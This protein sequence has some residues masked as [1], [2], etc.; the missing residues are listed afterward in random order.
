M[1]K[2][3][4]KK[5]LECKKHFFAKNLRAVYCSDRCRVRSNRKKSVTVT[6]KA[7]IVLSK[8]EILLKET[9]LLLEKEQMGIP[10]L[11]K[12][13]TE[14]EI[15]LRDREL[16]NEKIRGIKTKL[17]KARTYY[18]RI[19][20]TVKSG[21]EITKGMLADSAGKNLLL[22]ALAGFV[23]DKAMGNSIKRY[24]YSKELRDIDEQLALLG[25]EERII[26]FPFDTD[27]LKGE[28]QN[29]ARHI[30]NLKQ[31]CKEL[32]ET[33]LR[34]KSV[35]DLILLKDE[36]G[37]VS[38]KDVKNINFSDRIMLSGDMGIFIGA[39]EKNKCA[40]TLTG[41]Q[42]SGKTYF[43]FDLISKFIEL[44]YKV[45]YFSCEEGITQL[46]REK[47]DYYRLQNEENFKIRE[48][49]SLQDIQKFANSFDVIVIDSW[50]KLN[51]DIS[52]FD[53]LRIA[54]PNTIIVSI[55]QLTTSGQM[56]GGTMAAFDAGIN[57]ET[58]IV[59][60]KRI[61]MCTKNRYGK[62]GIRYF[63]DERVIK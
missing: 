3:H 50:G 8:E 18:D 26:L 42:G 45:A 22:N 24:D 19:H 57:I 38:A 20:G 14:T 37:F 54:F 4:P 34:N 11:E 15:K 47:I 27:S 46:T 41:K 52:E 28:I 7:E 60:G 40:I 6:E 30:E 35:K 23:T 39:I 25:K 61:A 36:H 13:L 12:K 59:D 62:T 43:S 17:L 29:K 32:E 10:L 44:K 21:G 49:A 53:K 63:I 33:V 9:R 56:R 58:S 31:K 16:R 51:T 55:F 2:N 5:C 48:E 1:S